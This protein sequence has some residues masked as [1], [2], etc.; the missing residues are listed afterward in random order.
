[1]AISVFVSLECA[2]LRDVGQKDLRG[3][4]LR[5]ASNAMLQTIKQLHARM[6]LHWAREALQQVI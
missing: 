3:F 6:G 1:M 5:T 2:L 4:G